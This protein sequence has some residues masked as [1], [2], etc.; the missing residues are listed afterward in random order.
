[1]NKLNISRLLL[2]LL[3]TGC[4]VTGFAQINPAV[5][6]SGHSL[7]EEYILQNQHYPEAELADKKSGDV[8]VAFHLDEKGVGSDYQIKESFSEAANA[9]ALDLVKKILW[10][11]ATQNM[12]PVAIDMDYTVRYHV[13]SYKRYWKKHERVEI[14]LTLEADDS[15]KIFTIHQLEETAKPYFAD[16]SNMANYI[17]SNL[18]YPQAAKAT[19]VSGTVRLDFVVE[20]DGSVSNITVK[21]SVGGGCDNEA[22]RLLQGTNWIP[23]V[24][25]GKYVRSHNTQDITF[26]IG[27]RHYQDGNSY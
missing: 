8:V 21:N 23:A 15:Y 25:N 11:P 22:I 14:P 12:L 4:F 10:E 2:V 13:K 7:T 9:D 3:F 26:N 6:K 16:G 5:P 20:T 18:E 27:S 1:M 17:L 24:K 19:E